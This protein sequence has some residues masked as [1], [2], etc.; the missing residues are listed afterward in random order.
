[1]ANPRLHLAETKP[2]SSSGLIQRKEHD[3][4]Y[5]P[6]FIAVFVRTVQM[7]NRGNV[8]SSKSSKIAMV[9]KYSAE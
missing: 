3:G 6:V 5:R 9:V 4:I 1:M 2:I 8:L 7:F